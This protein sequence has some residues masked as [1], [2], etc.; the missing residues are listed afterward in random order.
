[1]VLHLI[2][3]ATPDQTLL[4]E[5]EQKIYSFIQRTCTETEG[6]GHVSA[7]KRQTL[8]V[9]TYSEDVIQQI[10]SDITQIPD[11]KDQV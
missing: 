3:E 4:T 10:G 6:Q 1:M 2:L 9:Q 5:E 8:S 11:Q 7:D